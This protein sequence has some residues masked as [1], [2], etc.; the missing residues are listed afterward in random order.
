MVPK[1]IFYQGAL[2]NARVMTFRF[3]P[4]GPEAMTKGFASRSPSTVVVSVAIIKDSGSSFQAEWR[5]S[6]LI[7]DPFDRQGG[8]AVKST[9]SGFDVFFPGVFD[10]VVADAV[11][12]LDKHH[13]GRDA[14]A[15]NFGGIM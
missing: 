13:H 1:Y 15:G 12:A 14:E 4:G 10:F 8:Q 3:V 11:Q 2:T 5:K 9:D 7:I 6:Q